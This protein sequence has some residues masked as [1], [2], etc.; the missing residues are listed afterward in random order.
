MR[1]L[2]R[3]GLKQGILPP[4]Q[5]PNLEL[6]GQL[7]F[8]GP[9]VDKYSEAHKAAPELL[10]AG[11]SASS[12]WTANAATITPSIDTPDGKVHF[13]AANFV[14]NLHRHQEAD[15]SKKILKFIFPIRIILSHHPILPGSTIMGDEGAANHSRI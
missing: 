8:R 9:T 14:T 2:H 15:F 7:G 6:L 4:H 1:L 10:A 13:T 11:Y 12:M 3:M 5:R